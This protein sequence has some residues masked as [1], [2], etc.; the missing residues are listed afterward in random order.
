LE[1]RA[2]SR[3]LKR[4]QDTTGPDFIVKGVTAL[5]D[6][7]KLKNAGLIKNWP[8]HCKPIVGLPK[9]C[10]DLMEWRSSI[11][12]R[13]VF[14]GT[15]NPILLDFDLNHTSVKTITDEMKPSQIRL[16]LQNSKLF[17]PGPWRGRSSSVPKFEIS[18]SGDFGSPLFEEEYF[19]EWV[20]FLD[21]E[22][23]A[24]RDSLLN[25]LENKTDHHVYLLIGGAGTGK[26]SVLTNLAFNLSERGIGLYFEVNEGVRSYLLK[27]NRDVPGLQKASDPSAAQVILL[28]DPLSLEILKRRV[29]EAKKSNQRIVVAI[30]PTQWH[31]RKLA[32][33][34]KKFKEDTSFT[35]IYLRVS[36]RQTQGVGRPA[37]N[38]ILNFNMK[39]SSFV[40]HAKV[41]REHESLASNWK[42]CL[43]E[44]QFKN[45]TGGLSV[46]AV[47]WGPEV[48]QDLIEEVVQ[49]GN[50]MS[51]PDLLIGHELL[52]APP[53]IVLS[54]LKKAESNGL[55]HH[56]RDFGQVS[57]VRGTEYD[58]VAIFVPEKKWET[59]TSGKLGPGTSE[60]ESLNTT[61]TFL[62]RAKSH[63]GVFL[64]NETWFI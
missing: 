30:D 1:L 51:W 3:F 50:Q 40:D 12:S 23:Q 44:V 13:I 64:M 9:N 59:L 7:L 28:D 49:R 63:V 42:V 35:P 19:D 27:G 58:F 29:S 14:H 16:Q 20:H 61:L 47:G 48:F 41:K 4:L 17:D 21:L 31:E 45:P 15:S 5:E 36:Y 6:F 39:S 55:S 60:W 18:S 52:H 32:E 62:T 43:E 26:T 2:T 56:I 25:S 38:L 53:E 37:L 24:A 54:M 22:Q 11:R 10:P 8:V 34:W 46:H 57:K 33:R